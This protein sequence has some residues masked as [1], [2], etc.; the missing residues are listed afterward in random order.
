MT[1]PTGSSPIRGAEHSLLIEVIDSATIHASLRRAIQ[2]HWDRYTNLRITFERFNLNELMT[3]IPIVERARLDLAA[4]LVDLFIEGDIAPFQSALVG[5]QVVIAPIVEWHETVPHLI[6]GLHRALAL[7][8]G[9][10]AEMMAIAI[11]ATSMPLPV[12]S[13]RHVSQVEISHGPIADAPF[14]DGKGF[15]DFRPSHLFVNTSIRNLTNQAKE[16]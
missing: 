9:G 1:T 12:G 5:G 16:D 3:P 14:F 13:P 15:E 10:N 11:R 6:D 7:A 8:R 2:V 4:R